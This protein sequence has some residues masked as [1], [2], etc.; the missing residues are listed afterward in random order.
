[1]EV[2]AFATS[3]Q[4]AKLIPESASYESVEKSLAESSEL[5]ELYNKDAQIKEIVDMAK[6]MEVA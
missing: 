2:P 4:L 6:E 5:L 3:N 1:M